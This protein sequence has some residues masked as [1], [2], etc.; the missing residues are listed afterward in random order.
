MKLK[1]KEI[2]LYH[3]IPGGTESCQVRIEEIGAFYIVVLHGKIL[4]MVMFWNIIELQPID[5]N[6]LQK[7]EEDK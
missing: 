2:S 5:E 4:K 7:G 1:G 6:I 3:K